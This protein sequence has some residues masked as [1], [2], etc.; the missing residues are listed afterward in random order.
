MG[1][2]FIVL[3]V[4]K[5]PEFRIKVKAHIELLVNLEI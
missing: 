5:I 3:T 4:F 2:V 1:V